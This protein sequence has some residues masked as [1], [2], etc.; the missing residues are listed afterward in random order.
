MALFSHFSLDDGDPY[1]NRTRVFA[2]R[3]VETRPTACRKLSQFIQVKQLLALRRRTP[4]H[5]GTGNYIVRILYGFA[6]A[7]VLKEAKLTTRNARSALERGL[8]WRS[9]DTGM[10]LGYRKRAKGGEWLV[11]W[12]VGNSTYHRAMVGPADDYGI[13]G[14]LSF[15]QASTAARKLVSERRAKAERRAKGPRRTVRNVVD[16]YIAA[17]DARLR[18]QRPGTKQRSDAH[19]RLTKYVLADP[20]AEVALSELSE[21]DLVAWKEAFA[22]DKTAGARVRTKNDFKAALNAAHRRFR[23]QLPADFSE[24]V[25]WGLSNDNMAGAGPAKARDNQI[26]E[27]EAVRRIVAVAMD[28]DADGDVGRMVMLLAATG[29]RFS[30]LQRLTVGDVQADRERLFIPLSRK[31]QG[32]AHGHYPMRV[33]GDVIEALRPL[34]TGRRYDEPLLLHWRMKQVPKEDSWHVVWIRDYRGPWSSTSQ[35][36][37]HFNQICASI[38]LAGTIPYALRHSSI[39]RAIRAGLPIRLVA[40]MHDTSVVMI[41]RHYSRYIVDGLE[42]LTARAIVPMFRPRLRAA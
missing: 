33:G 1:E 30:Q 15:D 35:L 14:T 24:R 31:G 6:M 29:A 21:D 8:H 7:K 19:S 34:L 42:E 25:R 32:K 4:Y 5:R 12:F 23:R 2:V 36:T 41:E 13:A 20:I 18:E 10:H 11:R 40:A 17:R 39:V 22:L 27:D 38:G 28:Y 16:D 26:L 9:L 37:R 3:A